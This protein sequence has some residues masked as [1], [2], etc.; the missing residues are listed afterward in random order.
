IVIFPFWLFIGY[1]NV[2]LLRFYVNGL[3]FTIM[4]NYIVVFKNLKFF[5]YLK[6]LKLYLKDNGF[7]RYFMLYY[8]KIIKP[9]QKH[10]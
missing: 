2:K 3:S 9:L 8:S 5:N 4:A 10:P 7:L 6:S 1:L